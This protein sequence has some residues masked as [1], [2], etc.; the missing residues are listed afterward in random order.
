MERMARLRIWRLVWYNSVV[1]QLNCADCA[2]HLQAII[3]SG[4]KHL[5]LLVEMQAIV[6][7]TMP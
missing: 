4:S 6:F 2:E 5:T 3:N 1:C 7:H